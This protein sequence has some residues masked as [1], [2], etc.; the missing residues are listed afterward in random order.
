MGLSVKKQIPIFI[1]VGIN[2]TIYILGFFAFNKY[3]FMMNAETVWVDGQYWRVLT[4]M[5]LHGDIRHIIFNMISL[6]GLSGLLL[7]TQ[8]AWKYYLIYFGSGILGGFAE[9]GVRLAMGDSTWSLGASGAIMGLLG[10]NMAFYIRNSS[11][12]PKPVMREQMRRLIIFALINL[13]PENSSVDYFGHLF[14][15]IFG[16]LIGMAVQKKST[17]TGTM[18]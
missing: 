14:G 11:R 1:L 9:S 12:I 7:L 10:A 5:F 18:D 17:G 4:S 13:V 6:Y 15:L 8:P 2:V 3:D 16:F